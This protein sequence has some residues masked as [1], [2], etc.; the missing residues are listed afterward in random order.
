MRCKICDYSETGPRSLTH[1]EEHN[2]PKNK[3]VYDATQ[4]RHVC[5][6]CLAEEL[7]VAFGFGHPTDEEENEDLY[8]ELGQEDDSFGYPSTDYLSDRRVRSS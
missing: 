2:T 7:E 1:L 8:V 6:Q 3:V 4:D 5:Q